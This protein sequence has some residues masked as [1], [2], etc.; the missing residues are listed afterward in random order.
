MSDVRSNADKFDEI[1]K[2]TQIEKYTYTLSM[3][4]KQ[5]LNVEDGSFKLMRTVF[6]QNASLSVY[7]GA[8]MG[9]VSGH[10]LTQEG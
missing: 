4:E 10:D 8:K 2:N 7:V 3:S 1:L 6:S 9:G 5:E